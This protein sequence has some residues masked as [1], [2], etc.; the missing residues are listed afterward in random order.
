MNELIDKDSADPKIQ[1]LIHRVRETFGL[2]LDSSRL[3]ALLVPHFIQ[4]QHEL[5]IFKTW[6]LVGK[7]T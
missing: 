5:K 1:H 7:T 4:L 2:S 6:I 3:I